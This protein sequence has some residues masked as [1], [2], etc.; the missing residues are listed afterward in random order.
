VAAGVRV[1][2]DVAMVGFD[3]IEM[4]RYL[5]PPLTTVRVDTF[6][7]GER[8]VRFLLGRTLGRS[9]GQGRHEL[10]PTTLIVRRSCGSTRP[11]PVEVI[12]A[13]RAGEPNSQRE[14]V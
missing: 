13:R 6:Q 4:A 5:T 1:P 8:A 12:P 14:W 3:D 7:L 9:D 2:D 10:M 11:G